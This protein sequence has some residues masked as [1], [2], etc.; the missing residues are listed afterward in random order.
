MPRTLASF[1]QPPQ[2]SPQPCS[3]PSCFATQLHTRMKMLQQRRRDSFRG[4]RQLRPST[5]FKLGAGSHYGIHG[6]SRSEVIRILTDAGTAPAYALTHAN[7]VKCNRYT[8]DI[9]SK[10]I[11]IYIFFPKYTG[12]ML[13]DRSNTRPQNKSQQI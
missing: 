7:S 13:Q 9:P 3:G 11:R 12:N 4:Q 10:N 2:C 8:Q 5:V 6:S 1:P